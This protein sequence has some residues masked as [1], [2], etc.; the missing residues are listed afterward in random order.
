MCFFVIVLRKMLENVL[1]KTRGKLGKV[2]TWKSR[3]AGG[4][5]RGREWESQGG[6]YGTGLESG[7]PDWDRGQRLEKGCLQEQVTDSQDCLNM[8]RE[9]LEFCQSPINDGNVEQPAVHFVLWSIPFPHSLRRMISSDL[10]SNP[11]IHLPSPIH[12]QAQSV[13]FSFQL[14]Y[15]LL[16]NCHLVPLYSFK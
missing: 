8:W 2:R 3:N 1:L 14:L 5:G 7:C 12:C 11:P 15:F 4:T 13:D 9:V 16:E 10:S 6:S